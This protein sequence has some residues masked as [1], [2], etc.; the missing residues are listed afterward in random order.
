[1]SS[2][3]ESVFVNSRDNLSPGSFYAGANQ[4]ESQYEKAFLKNKDL[5]GDGKYETVLRYVDDSG[6]YREVQ[7]VMENGLPKVLR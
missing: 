6:E 2:T 1:M 4:F 3:W 7:V 5:D